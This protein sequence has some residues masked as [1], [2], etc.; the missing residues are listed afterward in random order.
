MDSITVLQR[1]DWL[2]GNLLYKREKKTQQ[3][4]GGLWGT[5]NQERETED[6]NETKAEQS[7]TRGKRDHNPEHREEEEK[8]EEKTDPNQTKNKK[9][10]G[11]QGRVETEEREGRVPS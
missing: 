2:R 7:R 3:H 1:Q 6:R 9:P 10:R 4:G 5:K 8:L 11:R